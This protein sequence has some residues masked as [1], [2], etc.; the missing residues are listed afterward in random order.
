MHNISKIKQIAIVGAGS[1]GTAVAMV[2]AETHPSIEVVM[3]AYEKGVASSI[4]KHNKNNLYLPEVELPENITASTSLQDVVSDSPVVIFATPSKVLPEIAAKTSK[5]L[6]EGAVVGYLTK[7]F[8]RID[9]Q[10]VTISKT[11]EQA[12]PSQKNKTVAISGPSHA[13]EVSTHYHTCLNVGSRDEAA[14]ETIIS[15]LNSKYLQCRGTD[16]IIGVEVGG[17]L[18][19]PAAIAAGIISVLPGCGDNLVGA[20][21]AEALK[22]MLLLGRFFEARDETIIDISG[23]GDLV[24]TALSEH[25]RNRRFGNDIGSLI[26]EKGYVLTWFDRF[27]LYIRPHLVL[28][29]MS[30]KLH[31]LAEGAYAIEPLIELAEE[32]G[33]IIPVYRSL[34][35]VLLN[36]KDPSLLVE[37]IK[38]PQKFFELYSQSKMYVSEKQQGLEG[39][40]GKA[41]SETIAS[42]AVAYLENNFASD[43]LQEEV[44]LLHTVDVSGNTWSKYEQKEYNIS[45]KNINKS[46]QS[47]SE[48]YTAK[49][50]DINFPIIRNIALSIYSVL[51]RF[52]ARGSLFSP[53]ILSGEIRAVKKLKKSTSIVY[54]LKQT[55][56]L[57]VMPL[58][59]AIRASNMAFPRFVFYREDTGMLTGLFFRLCG[60]IAISKGRMNNLIFR[61]VVFNYLAVMLEHGLPVLFPCRTG[62]YLE[63]FHACVSSS[64]KEH[65]GEISYFVLKPENDEKSRGKE[66]Y[67]ISKPLLLS[68]FTRSD[69][70]LEKVHTMLHRFLQD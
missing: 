18:K 4:N 21:I 22:E 55:S 63:E 44:R 37:T 7:G 5:Y 38:N 9:N 70:E 8:C 53:I 39:I 28:E 62:E 6:I 40:R 67:N 3:W 27:L 36:R 24:A 47:L 48:M 16:D 60:G 30:K 32:N 51:V 35:E 33:I 50:A 31:Y 34:F 68:E 29:R 17:T 57:K 61:T 2:A 43:R 58:L 1:W 66:Q 41:I 56:L 12:L 20:L 65:G 46:L 59:R 52:Y 25:S 54:I 13:E 19:N 15:L 45:E 64:M 42:K 26:I 69:G 23:L 49:I 14:R 10:I 11:I